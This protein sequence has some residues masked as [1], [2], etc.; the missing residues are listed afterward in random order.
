MNDFSLEQRFMTD[1]KGRHRYNVRHIRRTMQAMPSLFTNDAIFSRTRLLNP[2]IVF[3]IVPSILHIIH[4]TTM[5]FAGAPFL[6]YF[7]GGKLLPV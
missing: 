5:H 1:I 3:L 7:D 2:A 6:I 4:Y